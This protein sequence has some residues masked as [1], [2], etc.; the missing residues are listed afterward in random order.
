MKRGIPFLYKTTITKP[1]W[2]KTIFNYG[3]QKK[4][5]LQGFEDW[6]SQAAGEIWNQPDNI[7]F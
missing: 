7:A 5:Y 3:E 6:L 2:N 1:P 4:K